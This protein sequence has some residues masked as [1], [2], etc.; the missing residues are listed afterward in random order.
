MVLPAIQPAKLES[1]QWEVVEIGGE[2]MFALPARGYEALSRNMAEL[3]RWAREASYQLN[4]YR[5]TR[6]QLAPTPA[7]D[8]KEGK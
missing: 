1:V 3:A 5:Q 2:P 6:Q 4:F 8:I 7:Y